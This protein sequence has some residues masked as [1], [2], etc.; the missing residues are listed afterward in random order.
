[1]TV[2]RINDIIDLLSILNIMLMLKKLLNKIILT[3]FL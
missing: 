3:K 1:M 2:C